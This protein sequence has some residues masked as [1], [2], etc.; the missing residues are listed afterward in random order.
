MN[1]TFPLIF[2][3]NIKIPFFNIWFENNIFLVSQLMNSD[4]D[5]LSYTEFLDKFKIPIRPREYVIVMDDIPSKILCLL[6]NECNET[7]N[8]VYITNKIFIGHINILKNNIP[9]K[10]IRNLVNDVTYPPARF[11]WSSIFGDLNWHKAWRMVDKFFVNNK[12]KE[13]SYKTLHIIYPGKHV[14]ECFKLNIDYSYEFCS[15]EK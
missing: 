1:I 14:L 4:G 15:N 2:S 3:P 10:Y 11:F 12:V 6:K 9:N 8:L 7:P 13:V 5:L